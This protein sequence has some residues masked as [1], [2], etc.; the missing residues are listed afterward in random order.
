MP[1]SL[2]SPESL[3]TFL[4]QS[5]QKFRDKTEQSLIH[6]KRISDFK[7]QFELVIRSRYPGLR[8]A[9]LSRHTGPLRVLINTYSGTDLNTMIHEYVGKPVYFTNGIG[10]DNFYSVAKNIATILADRKYREN[11]IAKR[12]LI[13]EPISPDMQEAKK[14]QESPFFKKL[15]KIFQESIQRGEL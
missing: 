14:L 5:Q 7:R 9:W 11:L 8:I 15:P 3:D 2:E 10:F 12:K 13:A 4:W 1:E 6:R